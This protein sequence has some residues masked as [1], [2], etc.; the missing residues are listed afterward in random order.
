MEHLQLGG[1]AAVGGMFALFLLVGI[2]AARKVRE[3]SESSAADLLVAGRTLPLWLAV[4]T[5]TATWVDGGYLNGT[6][7]GVH[8]GNLARALQPGLCFGLSLILGGLFF[9]RTM[10]RHQFT[11]IVDPFALR[12]GEHWATILLLPALLGELFWSAELLVALGSTLRVLVGLNLTIAIVVSAVVVV[13]YTMLGGMWS[14]A[15]TDAFQLLLIPIGLLIALPF[16]LQA[17]G[18]LETCWQSYVTLHPEGTRIV[19]PLAADHT[20]T[21][22]ALTGWWDTSF[23]LILGGIPWNCYF[24]RVLSCSTPG[25]AVSHSILAGILTMA[26]T[27]P[28]CLLG[29]ATVAYWGKDSIPATDALPMLLHYMVPAGIGLIGLAAIV[30]AVTSSFSSSILSGGAMVSWNVY[31]TLIRPTATVPEIKRV[32]R[33][34][35]L[36]LGVAATLLA[37]RV[38]SVLALWIFTSDL[39]F[40]LLFPQLVMVLFDRKANRM[41][42]IT[43]FVVSLLLRLAG[44]EP[45]FGLPAWFDYSSL[46][47]PLLAGPL[48]S[49]YHAENGASLFPFRTL[50]AG[51]G[52]VLIPLV[53]RLT[54]RWDPPRALPA[55]ANTT[56]LTPPTHA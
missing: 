31:R 25:R 17:T 7:E 40:V 47:A 55:L 48:A 51:V 3:S 32:I 9:A 4:M 39:I 5:M 36:L 14:V 30:G 20:W 56:F 43:A 18:G 44:G 22:A 11:T 8:A 13:T 24:Q 2:V 28:P 53:S 23:M 41:G 15:Y 6:T 21:P 16:A 19:P 35:V 38:Q 49:W 50:A 52:L 26:L 34:A 27:I 42:S 46:G 33:L 37:W 1:L 10:R 12:Y 45:L 29:L 54:A